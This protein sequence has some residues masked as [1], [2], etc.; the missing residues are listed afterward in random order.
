MKMTLSKRKP[1]T[2]IHSGFTLHLSKEGKKFSIY[3]KNSLVK[4]L[5]D[6][7]SKRVR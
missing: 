1:F 6:C 2:K 5:Y 7:L 4:E 3:I